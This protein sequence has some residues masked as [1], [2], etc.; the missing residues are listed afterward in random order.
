[1]WQFFITVLSVFSALGVFYIATRVR[2]FGFCKKI[3]A[4]NRL[5]GWAVA[6]CLAALPLLFLIINVYAFIIAQ[7]HLVIIWALCD[8]ISAVWRRAAHKTRTAYL[9]G[10]CAVVFAAVYLGAGWFLAHHVFE[11]HYELFTEKPLPGGSLR[12]VEIADSHIGITLD[13]ED[14]A[15]E[16]LRVQETTPDIVVICGDFVDD[17]TRKT[18]MVRAC[19]ALGELKTKYGVYFIYGNHDEGYFN[20]RDFSSAELVENLENNGVVI[21]GDESATIAGSVCVA[22]RLDRTMKRKSAAGLAAECDMSAFTVLLD[23]QPNDYANESAAGF[24]L[25]LSGHTHGGHIF[26]AGAIGLLMGANDRV[27]GTE[28]R[29]GTTFIVTSGISGWGI[30]FK[31]GTISEYVVIDVKNK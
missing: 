5:A 3:S 31:T 7:V 15:L 28:V 8:L 16:M 1:M 19:A 30:P 20:Y 27:Y 24:D 13:G 17:D 2:E 12:I 11:T 6:V 14:F 10:L 4:K 26:P 29:G 9:A 25:V 18:D 21:L 22:G 23:H